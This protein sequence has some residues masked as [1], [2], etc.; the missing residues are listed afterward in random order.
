MRAL[1][2]LAT[3]GGNTNVLQHMAGYFKDRLG[4]AEKAEP[5]RPSPTTGAASSR[6]WCRSRCSATTCA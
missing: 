1:R 3:R 2:V 6:R 5:T 4:H